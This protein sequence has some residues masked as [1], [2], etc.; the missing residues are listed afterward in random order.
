MTL[1]HEA[2]GDG[3]VLVTVGST[4]DYDETRELEQLLGRLVHDGATRLA[5]DLSAAGMIDDAAVGLLFRALRQVRQNGG[6]VALC[7]PDAKQRAPLA[8]MGVD[9]HLPVLA[10]RE[11]AIA[12][13]LADG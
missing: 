11:A 5:I 9:R 2:I 12:A 3:A 1:S 13:V 10:T 4:L 7:M 8:V 6:R